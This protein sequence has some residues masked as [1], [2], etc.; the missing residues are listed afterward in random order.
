MNRIDNSG[1]GIAQLGRDEDKFLAH[2]AP[3]EMVVPPVITPETK[4]E[5]KVTVIDGLRS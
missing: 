4:S 3:N 5:K 2:V 1:M